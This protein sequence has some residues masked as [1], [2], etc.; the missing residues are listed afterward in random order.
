MD[1]WSERAK[2]LAEE[3]NLEQGWMELEEDRKLDGL[4]KVLGKRADLFIIIKTD[5]HAKV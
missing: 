2:R 5:V 3:A 1:P 4:R